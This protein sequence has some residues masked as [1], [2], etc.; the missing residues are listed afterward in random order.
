MIQMCVRYKN[1]INLDHF[2]DT[3]IPDPGSGIN[4][5]IIIQQH[6]RG[7]RSTANTAAASQD[8]QFQ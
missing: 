7:L 4:Q 1:V 8:P 2:L 5:D 3:Q 6:R